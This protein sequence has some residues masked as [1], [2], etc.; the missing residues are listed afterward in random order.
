MAEKITG[1]VLNVRKYNDKN[2]I[3]TLYTRERGRMAFISPLGSGKASNARRARLQP[4]SI[5]STDLNYKPA[6]E[7]QRLGPINP[8]E[9]WSDIYF[10]SA[11]RIMIIFISEFLYRL[12]NAA[13][14]DTAL[15]DFLVDAIRL[16]DKS[17]SGVSDFHIPFL[18]SLLSYSGIQPDVSGYMQGYV[19]DFAS[20]SFIPSFEAT[21]PFIEEREASFVPLIS[22]I[23]FSNIKCLRLNAINRRQILYGLLNYFSYHF[24]GVGSLKSPDI[25]REIFE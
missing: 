11:K 3:V 21:G 2:C 24:P 16:L 14:P 18:V 7:L 17:R 19:F 23:N 10:D 22:K 8:V 25:L 6:N 1:I 13:M 15:F 12:L 5:I 4:L 9:V 20:G